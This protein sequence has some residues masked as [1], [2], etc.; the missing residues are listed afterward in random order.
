MMDGR[1]QDGNKGRVNSMAK[2]HFIVRATVAPELRDKFERWYTADHLPWAC[3]V[4]KCEKAWRFWSEVEEGVHYAAYQ[5]A[6]KAACDA[7]LGTA[8]FKD[9]IADFTRAWPDGVTRTRDIVTLVEER[10]SP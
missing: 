5:F 4:F 8:E 2:V 7:A 3:R 1:R 10:A 9:M 6:D